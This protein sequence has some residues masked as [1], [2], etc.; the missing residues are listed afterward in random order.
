MRFKTA[1]NS[2]FNQH[3][4]LSQRQVS[5]ASE[6][7]GPDLS[8]FRSGKRPITL[9]ALTK[10]LPTITELSSRTHAKALLVAYLHDETPAAFAADVLIEPVEAPGNVQQDPIIIARD[11]W[12]KRA[13]EDVEFAKMWL[14]MDGYMHEKSAAAVD[15]K[16]AA[17]TTPENPLN[18]LVKEVLAE[19][20]SISKNTRN[21]KDKAS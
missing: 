2:W 7:P 20:D 12:E 13:R 21:A 17:F 9:D 1:L 6:V 11:R 10:L 18:T 19:G 8:K 15:S 3:P 5:L 14:T 4:A 16:V